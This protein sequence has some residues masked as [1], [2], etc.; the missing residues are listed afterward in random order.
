MQKYIVQFVPPGSTYNLVLTTEER[1]KLEKR[2]ICMILKMTILGDGH[3]DKFQSDDAFFEDVKEK[4][5]EVQEVKLIG[6]HTTTRQEV[7]PSEVR[8]YSFLK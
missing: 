4:G 7:M 2:N 3:I 6:V 1:N 8:V 5:N